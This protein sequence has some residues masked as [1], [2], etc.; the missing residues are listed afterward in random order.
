MDEWKGMLLYLVVANI[1]TFIMMGLDKQKA[2]KK[3]YR[4]PERTFWLLALVGGSLGAIFGMRRYRH[5]TK[6][7]TFVWGMPILLLVNITCVF[8]ILFF[9]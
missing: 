9:Y 3:Q 1:I 4:I 6:H 8:Y 5:K 2:R 7:K